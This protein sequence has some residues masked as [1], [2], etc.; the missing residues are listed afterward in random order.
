MRLTDTTVCQNVIVPQAWQSNSVCLGIFHFSRSKR[1]C[2]GRSNSCKPSP[3]CGQT[4]CIVVRVIC[5]STYDLTV[6]SSCWWYRAAPAHASMTGWPFSRSFSSHSGGEASSSGRG[7][8][9]FT[10]QHMRA[11][12][13]AM[14]QQ[15][16]AM[17]HVGKQAFEVGGR[18]RMIGLLSTVNCMPIAC[19]TS[20]T[21]TAGRCEAERHDDIA[22]LAQQRLGELCGWSRIGGCMACL[23]PSDIRCSRGVG[24]WMHCH[25]TVCY[26]HSLCL[27]TLDGRSPGQAAA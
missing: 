13:E 14:M 21:P 27:S 24:S 6:C 8:L 1:V 22:P 3:A 11:T 16:G 5:R 19:L 4:T 7:A 9:A 20:H 2:V 18:T 25:P 12:S 15:L 10:Q 23:Q 26:A 17:Q